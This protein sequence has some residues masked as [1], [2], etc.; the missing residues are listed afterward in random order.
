M[1]AKTKETLRV[2][3]DKRLRL[4]FHGAKITSDAGLLAC[5]EYNILP[6]PVGAI[7]GGSSDHIQAASIVHYELPIHDYDVRTT[8]KV[9]PVLRIGIIA[10]QLR[11]GQ[12]IIRHGEDKPVQQVVGA[13]DRL[14]AGIC[15]V[16]F[17]I[18]AKINK[19]LTRLEVYV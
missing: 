11:P 5:R 10:V 18:Q 3:F 4:E 16:V 9:I 13:A 2:Q 14:P 17:A 12:A 15:H 1:G 19:W 8:G 7:A 6:G